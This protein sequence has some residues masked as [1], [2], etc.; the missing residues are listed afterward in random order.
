MGKFN[1]TDTEKEVMEFFW[2]RD[3]KFTFGEIYDYFIKEKNKTWKKQTVQTFL[4][5]LVKKGVLTNEKKGNTYL[6]FLKITKE[7]YIQKWTKNFLD[8]TFDGSLKKFLC[9]LSGGD[10]LEPQIAD[11]LKEYFIKDF[12][13]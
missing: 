10:S 4:V 5:H 12:E 9:A 7:K 8:T 3:D 6:Y 13:K 11:E 2:N 1:L